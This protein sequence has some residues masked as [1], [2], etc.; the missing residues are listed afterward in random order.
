MV[1]QG[2]LALGD[3]FGHPWL[4]GVPVDRAQPTPWKGPICHSSNTFPLLPP[5]QAEHS[6]DLAASRGRELSPQSKLQLPKGPPSQVPGRGR[7]GQMFW[8]DRGCYGA[9]MGKGRRGQR[10]MMESS[11]QD[12][13]RGEGEKIPRGSAGMCQGQLGRA[14]DGPAQPRVDGTWLLWDLPGSEL[15]TAPGSL[16]MFPFH[17]GASLPHPPSP[18]T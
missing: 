4:L 18:L 14:V 7:R 2:Q 3:A 17:A 8:G 15:G 16:W 10:A 13:V 12:S 11:R 5:A 1:S 9:Q 6:P